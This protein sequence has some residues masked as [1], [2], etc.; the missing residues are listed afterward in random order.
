VLD[1]LKKRLML[2]NAEKQKLLS[3]LAMSY[4]QGHKT[5]LANEYRALVNRVTPEVFRI[6]EQITCSFKEKFEIES[7]YKT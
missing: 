4:T 1:T 7:P 3:M 2:L 5:Q 6:A